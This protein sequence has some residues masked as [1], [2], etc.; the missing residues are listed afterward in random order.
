MNEVCGRCGRRL[1]S[2]RSRKLG[3][4][5]MCWRRMRAAVAELRA[6]VEAGKIGAFL[7]HQITSA[8]ELIDDGGVAYVGDYSFVT[9]STDGTERYTTS[10][11]DCTCPAGER[12]ESCY[13]QAAVVILE[14]VL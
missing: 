3:F 13:H 12:G 5:E 8:Q 1:T 10:I 7:P 9:I 4:G 14:A 6:E 2:A 11:F